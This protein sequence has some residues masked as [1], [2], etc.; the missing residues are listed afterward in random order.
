M[1]RHLLIVLAV[2]AWAVSSQAAVF[3]T[4]SGSPT[5]GLPGYTTWTVFANTND[6]SQI[7]GFDFAS[8]PTFGFFGPMNQVNPAGQ[9]TVFQ[10][11]NA[12]FPFVGADVSQDS[13]FK[14]LSA[15][16]TKPAGFDSEG[17]DRLRSVFAAPAPLGTSVQFAQLVI[18]NL[19]W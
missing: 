18:P 19:E 8:Q 15:A 10:D 6:G 2:L 11:N 13:Q 14:F 9:R 5:V 16:V 12:F 7:R 1:L 3:V 4:S 17:P